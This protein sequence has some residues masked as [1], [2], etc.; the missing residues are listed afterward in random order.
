MLSLR[1]LKHHKR[2]RPVNI[3][4]L[5]GGQCG[6]P[7]YNREVR[8]CH[9]GSVRW[10]VRTKWFGAQTARLTFCLSFTQSEKKKNR[11]VPAYRA[12][13]LSLGVLVFIFHNCTRFCRACSLDVDATAKKK[14]VTTILIKRIQTNRLPSI[15]FE[16]Q[17]SIFVRL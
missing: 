6:P 14:S 10:R 5:R 2:R 3:I 16:Q 17:S 1:T 7:G 13:S 15:A 4:F 8:C 12:I 11:R 9:V